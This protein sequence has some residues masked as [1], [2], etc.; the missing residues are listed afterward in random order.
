MRW[1]IKFDDPAKDVLFYSLY[2]GA[3]IEFVEETGCKADRVEFEKVL[4]EKSD[5]FKFYIYA[6]EH[7]PPHFHVFFNGQEDSFSILDATP[8][9]QGCG[10]KKYLKNIQKWHGSNRSRLI[11]VLNKSRPSDCPSEPSLSK[12]GSCVSPKLEE[13]QAPKINRAA[14]GNRWRGHRR[15][16]S[17]QL[18]G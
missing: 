1:T 3:I 10:L 7:H 15:N 6:D 17:A 4:V 5:G 14:R 13:P 18:L 16:G 12:E 8:L 2:G 11:E 9:H